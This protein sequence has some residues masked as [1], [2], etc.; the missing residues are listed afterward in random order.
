MEFPAIVDDVSGGEKAAAWVIGIIVIAVIV[1]TLLMP[2]PARGGPV[3][4]RRCNVPVT[5]T[6]KGARIERDQRINTTIALRLA[7]RMQAPYKHHVA[8]VAA[9]TQEDSQRNRVGGHGT[10]VGYLQLINIHGSVAWRMRVENSAGWFLRGAKSL[11]PRGTARLATTRR[12][13]G[14][15]QRIQRSGHPEAYNKWIAEAASTYKKYRA[16][17]R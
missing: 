6:V 15:I 9:A 7:D 8:V 3:T 5:A 13:D 10:S 14:L 4:P 2:E 1:A 12:G 17:C 16:S 11:D